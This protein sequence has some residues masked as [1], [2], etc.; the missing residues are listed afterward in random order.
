MPDSAVD[1][2]AASAAA[3]A[4]SAAT[5]APPADSVA[6]V[7]DQSSNV[8]LLTQLLRLAAPTS[9]V[10]ALQ[11]VSQVT[12]TWLAARQGTA[13]LAGWAVILPFAL[14]MQQMSTGA[15]GGGVVS[16]IARALGAKKNEEASTLVQHA[17]VIAL[18]AG[19]G[20]ALSMSLGGGALVETV[21]GRE[22][23]AATMGYVLL[24][25]GVGAIPTWL[26]NTL[27]SVLRGAGR[28]GLAARTLVA[29]WAGFPL[30]AWLL[31][32]PLRLGMSGIGAAFALVFLCASASMSLVVL[33]GGAGFVPSLRL[34]LS[35]ALFSRILAVGATACVLS[36]L[37]NLTTIVVTS[38]MRLYGPAAVAAYGISARLEFLVVPIAFAVG[39][40]LTAM[41]GMAVGEEDWARA[42][43]IARLGGVLA[44]VLTGAVGIG[45]ALAPMRFAGFFS[46][47]PQVVSVAA[48]A[49]RFVGPAL[50]FFG[51][52]L[53][54]YFA[55]L[56]AG[57][58]L[59]PVLGVAARFTTAALGGVL[60]AS[61]AGMGMQGY[62]LS[63]AL[64]LVA[65]G[66]L[67]SVGIRSS[68]WR[69]R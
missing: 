55:S 30:L 59:F 45:A 2:A 24:I 63:V 21:A 38:Q 62:F 29:T 52:G 51:L 4:A 41:V 13:A 67:T 36:L 14:L 31:A 37:H 6:P 3:S 27:A 19:A 54:M 25:F 68:V 33:R 65:F 20:F 66:C 32:E 11:V 43:R 8:R 28:H 1:S 5:P 7:H 15:M 12:E 46:N 26:V 64:G 39:S 47:D 16:A 18:V 49:I 40:A 50:C 53:A 17:C 61:V 42:R 58:L 9:L 57:R 10:A 34:H 23:R 69:I 44:F 22:A 60:L 35:R 48:A 56:G